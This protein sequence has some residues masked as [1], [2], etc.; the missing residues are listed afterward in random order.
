MK[1]LMAVAAVS[2]TMLAAASPALAQD[3]LATD[4]SV[5]LGGDVLSVDA[6]QA[7]AAGQ[8][9]TGDATALAS[10]GGVAGAGN[11]AGIYQWQYNGGF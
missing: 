7:Q 4:G 11:G 8:V 10:D 1:K 5:A 3:A 9:Q 2:V 6:S